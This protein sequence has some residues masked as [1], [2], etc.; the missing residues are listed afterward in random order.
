[1]TSGDE[2]NIVIGNGKP[3]QI[4]GEINDESGQPDAFGARWFVGININSVI[5][6]VLAGLIR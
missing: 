5:E 1:M 4:C 6:N 3:R 2:G